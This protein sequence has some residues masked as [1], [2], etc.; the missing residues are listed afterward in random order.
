[1]VWA[2]R[3]QNVYKLY[4]SD[5]NVLS[6]S[7]RSIQTERQ[8]PLQPMA[9]LWKPE[10]QEYY[11]PV[12]HHDVGYTCEPG[13]LKTL[14]CLQ[15][16]CTHSNPSF[17]LCFYYL[18]TLFYWRGNIRCLFT[19]LP[20]LETRKFLFQ[21]SSLEL[22]PFKQVTCFS[23]IHYLLHRNKF[24]LQLLPNYSILQFCGF[25]SFCFLI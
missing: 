2:G 20:G 14:I 18:L 25:V 1:M 19:H 9:F 11:F 13:F 7:I 24:L 5:F 4:L 23:K 12:H 3:R 8:A 22:P 21:G 6:P 17:K 16:I 10:S 15:F